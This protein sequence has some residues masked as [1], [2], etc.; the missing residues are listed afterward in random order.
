MEKKGRERSRLLEARAQRKYMEYST[1]RKQLAA[2]VPLALELLS[3]TTERRFR[4]LVV[5]REARG[6]AAIDFESR[7]EVDGIGRATIDHLAQDVG[8]QGVSRRFIG[9]NGPHGLATI[10][11]TGQLQSA[12]SSSWTRG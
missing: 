11:R 2:R 9:E 7:T 12:A 5:R 1:P 6:T 3:N 10:H 8:E 4:K